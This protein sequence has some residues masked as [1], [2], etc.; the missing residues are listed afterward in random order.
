MNNVFNIF[1]Q[2]VG[3]ILLVRTHKSKLNTVSQRL[4][5][6]GSKSGFSHAILCLQSGT[7]V[8]S[9][10]FGNDN[11]NNGVR[12]FCADHLFHRLE[13]EYSSWKVVRHK[14]IDSEKMME[15]SNRADYYY[16]QGYNRNFITKLSKGDYFADR[17]YCSEFI[18]RVYADIGLKRSVRN[19]C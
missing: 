13:N 15:I 18:A 3:D 17:S 11:D 7:Y 8:E 9:N 16:G 19:Q 1:R 2:K 5:T 6:S 10:Y 4:F 14:A 12:L